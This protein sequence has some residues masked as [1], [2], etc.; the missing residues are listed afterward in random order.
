MRFATLSLVLALVAFLVGTAPSAVAGK[1]AKTAFKINITMEGS[2]GA[3]YGPYDL[4]GTFRASGAISA[5]G[6]ATTPLLWDPV[7]ILLETAEGSL[8]VIASTDETGAEVFGIAGGTGAYAGLSG[9][10]SASWDH[11]FIYPKGTPN[12][13]KRYGDGWGGVPSDRIRVDVQLTGTLGGG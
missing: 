13:E 9:G 12:K 3:I 4:N 5:S 2:Y 8:T 1:K 7:S 11:T 6:S 10:G